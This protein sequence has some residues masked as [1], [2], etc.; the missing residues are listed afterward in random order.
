LNIRGQFSINTTAAIYLGFFDP[1]GS[2]NMLDNI[3]RLR[4]P[5]RHRR[6]HPAR[7]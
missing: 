5:L 6:S 4:E 2:A 7:A 1:T 3:S